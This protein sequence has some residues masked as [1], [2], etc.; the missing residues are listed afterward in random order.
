MVVHHQELP[1]CRIDIG[2]EHL[3]TGQRTLP[4]F[5]DIVGEPVPLSNLALRVTRDGEDV[6]VSRHTTRF[7]LVV[8]L[9]SPQAMTSEITRAREVHRPL[10]P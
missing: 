3:V 10:S 2:A 9:T 6:G 7:G 1:W 8:D 4:R 5:R